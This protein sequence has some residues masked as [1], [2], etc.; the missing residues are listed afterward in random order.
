MRFWRCVCILTALSALSVSVTTGTPVSTAFTYQGKLTDWSGKPISGALDMTFNLF[1]S[2]TGGNQVGETDAISGV[3]VSGGLF[4]V[5]LDFGIG[6]FRGDQRWV[7]TTVGGEIIS[8]RVQ[9]MPIPYA[10]CAI[11]ATATRS[12]ISALLGLSD[13]TENVTDGTGAVTSQLRKV[14]N[15]ALTSGQPMSLDMTQSGTGTSLQTLHFDISKAAGQLTLAGSPDTQVALNG[16]PVVTINVIAGNTGTTAVNTETITLS[17]DAPLYKST[18]AF[19]C[20]LRASL[21]SDNQLCL[22]VGQS[23]AADGIAD[24]AHRDANRSPGIFQR[25]LRRAHHSRQP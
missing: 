22:S 1:D 8:P 15:L 3:N 14:I 17:P 16:S 4:C 9:M 19:S 20:G 6:A 23:A 24:R 21:V 7:E 11:N 13:I 25:C 2:L 12:Y 5:P 10:T 18:N